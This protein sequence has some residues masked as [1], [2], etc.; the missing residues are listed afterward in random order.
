M[1][2]PPSPCVSICTLDDN[3]VC[4]GCRRT[5]EEIRRWGRLAASEQWRIVADLKRR[6]PGQ[7]AQA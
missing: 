3:R 7:E 1:M 2:P 6:S 5:L 4:L